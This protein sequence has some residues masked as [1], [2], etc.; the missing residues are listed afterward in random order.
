[1]RSPRRLSRAI[2]DLLVRAWV[3]VGGELGPSGS[4]VSRPVFEPCNHVFATPHAPSLGGY[5]DADGCSQGPPGHHAPSQP[6]L[7][8]AMTGLMGWRGV[9]VTKRLIFS[10]DKERGMFRQAGPALSLCYRFA[11]AGMKLERSDSA[12]DLRGS[13]VGLDR[14]CWR[15][16]RVPACELPALISPSCRLAVANPG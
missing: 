1:M 4:V 11:P 16:G 5:G 6:S 14:F 8:I 2:N 10:E 9:A 7:P 13:P 15:G 3:N 12:A